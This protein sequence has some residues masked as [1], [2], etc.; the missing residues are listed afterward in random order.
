[1]ITLFFFSDSIVSFYS[2]DEKE[3]AEGCNKV[4]STQAIASQNDYKVPA[5]L[6]EQDIEQE[7]NQLQKML[8]NP[9]LLIQR[10]IKRL[11]KCFMKVTKRKM[12]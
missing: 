1:M 12:L 4:L 7:V 2:E 3:L 11:K 10:N 5:H 9:P 8:C 6:D